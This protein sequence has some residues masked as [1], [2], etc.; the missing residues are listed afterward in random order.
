MLHSGPT[1]P[2]H[3]TNV[4]VVVVA[5]VVVVESGT[6]EHGS[7]GST[8]PP[9]GRSV[10][11][12]VDDELVDVLAATVDDDVVVGATVDV[13][14][15]QGSGTQVPA[16]M[17]RPPAVVQSAADWTTQRNA[18]PDEPG[19][20]FDTTNAASDES[21]TQHW[22]I[23]GAPVVD[24]VLVVLVVVVEPGNVVVVADVVVVPVVCVVVVVL[25]EGLVVTLEQG[26]EPDGPTRLATQATNAPVAESIFAVSSVVRQSPLASARAKPFASAVTQASEQNAMLGSVSAMSALAA[27]AAH[28]SRQRADLPA[29]RNLSAVHLLLAP[30]ATRRVR[31]SVSWSSMR[32]PMAV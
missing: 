7:S 16:P 3:G 12:V 22:I 27:F 23:A 20:S 18:P 9:H 28:A 5:I 1:R 8:R 25:D 30:V 31:R 10:I 14:V 17:S 15:G 21:G 19:G 24:V 32:S 6:H 29:C 4:V 13:V 26:V 11:V 2:P